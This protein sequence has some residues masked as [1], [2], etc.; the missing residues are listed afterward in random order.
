MKFPKRL[1]ALGVSAAVVLSCTAPAFAASSVTK[2]ETVYVFLNPN[3]SVARQSS[4]CWVHSDQGIS[5]VQDRSTLADIHD[6]HSDNAPQRDGDVLHWDSDDHDIYYTGTPQGT[7]PIRVQLTWTLDG[8]E[9]TA[10]QLE[11]RSGHVTLHLQMENTQK[12]SRTI[13]GQQRTL[14]T[15]FVVIGGVVF[16]ADHFTDV[17]VDH[18]KV[19]TDASRQLAA[20]T[21]LPGMEENFRGLLDGRLSDV[22]DLF[23][24]DILLEADT[25]DFRMP[26]IM[27][28]AATSL[29]ELESMESAGNMSEDLD[30]LRSATGDL[31]DGIS[32]LKEGAGKLDEGA[33]ALVTGTD[34][35]DQGVATLDDGAG[36]LLEGSSALKEGAGK[37]DEGLGTLVTGSSNLNNGAATLDGGA[38]QLAAGASSLKDATSQLKTG[39]DTLSQ[40]AAQLNQGLTTL[41]GQNTALNGGMAQLKAGVDQFGTAGAQLQQAVAGAQSGV[42]TVTAQY[43]ALMNGYNELKPQ[44]EGISAQ[45]PAL[46]GELTGQV[47]QAVVQAAGSS[48]GAVYDQMAGGMQAALGSLDPDAL[49]SAVQGQMGDSFNAETFAATLAAVQG[50]LNG[51]AAGLPAR[52]TVVDA[53]QQQAAAAAAPQLEA[54]GQKIDAMDPAGLAAKADAMNTQAQDLMNTTAGLMGSLS[55]GTDNDNTTLAGALNGLAAGMGQLPAGVTQL[56]QGLTA[57]TNGV[58][59]AAAASTQLKD[60]ASSLAAGAAKLDEGA[61]ALHSNLLTLKGGVSQLKEGTQS[62]H[63]GAAQLKEGAGKLNGGAQELNGGLSTLKDGSG[64]LKDG[65]GTLKGGVSQLKDGTSQLSEGARTLDEGANTYAN[66]GIYKLTD[67]AEVKDLPALTDVISELQNLADDY[68]SY[69]GAPEGVRSTVKFL[70]KVQESAADTDTEAEQTD[71]QPAAQQTAAAPKSLWQRIRD[72]F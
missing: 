3:G 15:P 34:T 4:S 63:N 2:D 41:S 27:M 67:A 46:K 28:A 61:I 54:L 24:D 36:K 45:L 48:A 64:K 56:Q 13:Q 57:Y 18:G 7:P 69:S 53:A 23:V 71:A 44:L 39:S 12:Y 62:L 29:E 31:L 47:G 70:Y 59:Q 50:Q 52:E 33:D 43:Q 6:L 22:Q 26:Q 17:T 66:D 49:A 11:G 37:L 32:K 60:G 10:Q 16:D 8:E 19:Q 65:T 20:F 5:S 40:G 21:A 68:T 14:Y 30:T 38:G 58:A 72:L 51:A 35:L 1:A 9:A 55:N 25:T 42:Q